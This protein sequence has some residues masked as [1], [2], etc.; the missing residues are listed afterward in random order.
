MYGIFITYNN[1]KF[2]NIYHRIL[3]NRQATSFVFAIW[4]FF[5]IIFFFIFRGLRQNGN[6]YIKA[7]CNCAYKQKYISKGGIFAFVILV[8]TKSFFLHKNWLDIQVSK[9]KCSKSFLLLN[10]NNINERIYDIYEHVK[11][12]SIYKLLLINLTWK[13]PQAQA[14]KGSY[15]VDIHP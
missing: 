15:W 8:D 7:T 10:I 11:P 2:L 13:P 5:F 1:L 12:H 3:V 6:F 14:Q 9:I 4:W